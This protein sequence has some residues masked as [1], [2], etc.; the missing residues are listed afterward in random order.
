MELTGKSLKPSDV[1]QHAQLMGTYDIADLDG[2]DMMEMP[3]M[4]NHTIDSKL[5]YHQKSF[6]IITA[7]DV[8]QTFNHI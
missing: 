7:M 5:L 8:Y 2:F 4:M 1:T 3:T 6:W